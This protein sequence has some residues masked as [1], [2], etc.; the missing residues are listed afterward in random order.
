MQHKIKL[1]KNKMEKV[2]K[3]NPW[4]GSSIKSILKKIDSKTAFTRAG[5]NIHT[6]AELVAHMIGWREFMLKRLQGDKNFKMYQK[7]S[8]N[9]ERIDNNEKTAW[10]S[11][12]DALEK[13]QK[14]IMATLNKLNDDFLNYPVHQRKYNME[15]LVEGKI[16]HDIYHLGQISLLRKLI[17]C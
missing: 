12:L 14:E 7:L 15:F 10:K 8:F 16:Q 4:Y 3:G 6:I 13:N 17:E 1:L 5:K 9:W 2:Y 11:L